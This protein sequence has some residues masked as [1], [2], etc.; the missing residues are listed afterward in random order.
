MSKARNIARLN[1]TSNGKLGSSAFPSL[2]A[3]NV[4]SSVTYDTLPAGAVLQVKSYVYTWYNSVTL[5]DQ[6]QQ[7]PNLSLSITPKRAN[8]KFRIDIRWFG[9]VSSA[10][11]VTMGI[12]RNGSIIN[13][14][15]QEYSRHGCLAMPQQ[16]YVQDDNDSTPEYAFYSTIDAPGTTNTITYAAVFRCYSGTRTIMTGRVFS[17][18]SNGNYEQGS[19]EIIITEYAA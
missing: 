15:T 12:T 11:D 3:S 6:W 10:W 13:L 8:S 7:I 5:T 19:Q 18:T 9:E 16:T 14:P 17:G 4:Q 2:N 1:T